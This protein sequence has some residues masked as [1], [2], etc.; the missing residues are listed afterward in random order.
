[1]VRAQEKLRKLDVVERW[2]SR[3]MVF[4]LE[5]D[6]FRGVLQPKAW[7]KRWW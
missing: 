6:G 4:M 7:G 2:C 1:M 5:L 3:A